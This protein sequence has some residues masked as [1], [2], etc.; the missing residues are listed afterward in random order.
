MTWSTLPETLQLLT[1]VWPLLIPAVV[2]A[3]FL[4]WRAWSPRTI[5][6]VYLALTVSVAVWFVIADSRNALPDIAWYA[7]SLG[8]VWLGFWFWRRPQRSLRAA[9]RVAAVAIWA[10]T[11]VEMT[12]TPLLLAC[13]HGDCP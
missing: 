4:A 9:F 6:A 10:G 5:G 1:W 3:V 7:G 11:V 8:L 12:W 2:L 13:M